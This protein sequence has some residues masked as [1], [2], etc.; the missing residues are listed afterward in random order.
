ME[1]EYGLCI[2]VSNE[3]YVCTPHTYI[4]YSPKPFLKKIRSLIIASI[5][6]KKRAERDKTI[7]FRKNLVED[8]GTY[9]SHTSERG[10]SFDHPKHHQP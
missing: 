2:T 1:V 5:I 3:F 10:K 8:S 7:D 9:S 4:I 6:I